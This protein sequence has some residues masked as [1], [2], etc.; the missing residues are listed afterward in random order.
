MLQAVRRCCGRE[1]CASHST[2]A[3]GYS[4]TVFTECGSVMGDT[5]LKMFDSHANQVAYNDDA[6]GF[7]PGIN[8]ASAFKCV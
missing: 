3:Q 4:Y 6:Q 8:Y 7:C 1:L 2:L 5:L